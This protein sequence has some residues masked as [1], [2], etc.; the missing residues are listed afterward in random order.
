MNTTLLIDLLEERTSL[1]DMFKSK[2]RKREIR[3]VA[4]KE[5]AEKLIKIEKIGY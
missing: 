1:W 5:I 3:K 2:Y 4:Y